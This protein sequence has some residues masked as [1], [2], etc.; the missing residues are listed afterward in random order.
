[1]LRI[2]EFSSRTLRHFV[3]CL[4]PGSDA[5]ADIDLFPLP[6]PVDLQPDTVRLPVSRDRV[7]VRCIRLGPKRDFIENRIGG[8]FLTEDQP[9]R[10]GRL[11]REREVGNLL[12]QGLGK[13]IGGLTCQ[14]PLVHQHIVPV[15]AIRA[16]GGIGRM[17]EV[18]ADAAVPEADIP[19]R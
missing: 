6:M 8:D 12:P 17:G 14:L 13:T 11:R 3:G 1:M 9:R 10:D 5:T 19:A 16:D 18:A 4:D 7:L 15:P 2:G